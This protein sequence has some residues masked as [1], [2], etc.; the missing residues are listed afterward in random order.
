MEL[1]REIDLK[2][3]AIFDS[4]K[5]VGGLAHELFPGV[6]DA[7]TE[8]PSEFP[9]SVAVTRKLINEGCNIIYVAAFRWCACC[10]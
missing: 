3:Q 9:L 4:G 1:I 7:I 6:T 2:Q 5:S 8:N 10:Q